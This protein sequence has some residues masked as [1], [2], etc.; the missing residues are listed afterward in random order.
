MKAF[1]KL[2][3]IINDRIG[4]VV[5]DSIAMLYRLELG[6]SENIQEV[7]RELGRQIGYIKCII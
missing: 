1:E 4:L 6:K 3:D 2:K 7:N 5:V